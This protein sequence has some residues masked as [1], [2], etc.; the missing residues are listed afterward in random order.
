MHPPVVGFRSRR[1]HSK[2]GALNEKTER[3]YGNAATGPIKTSLL[4]QR[5]DQQMKIISTEVGF[6]IGMALAL[7]WL[8]LWWVIS[9]GIS[10]FSN[11]SKERWTIC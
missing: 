1:R 2:K 9:R 11:C 10:I 6:E 4:A 8:Q 7:I 3:I 5:Y